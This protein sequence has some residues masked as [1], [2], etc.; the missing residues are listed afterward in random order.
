MKELGI[1]AKH[2]MKF[3]VTTDSWHKYPVAENLLNRNFSPCGPNRCWVADISYIY[4]K[5]SAR[6]KQL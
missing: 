3:K 1:R 4:T 6:V 2:K 5:E